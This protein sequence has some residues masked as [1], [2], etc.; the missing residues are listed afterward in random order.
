MPPEKSPNCS[1]TPWRIGS[2]ASKRCAFLTTWMPTHSAAQWSI[3]AKI[4][5]CPSRSV[6][7][8]VAS[9]P[10]IWFGRS[11]TNG[12]V[13][14]IGRPVGLTLG[15]QQLLLAHH[16]QDTLFPHTHAAVSQSRPDLAIS[17]A[18]ED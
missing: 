3:A 18:N 1:R 7:V 14:R 13:V 8:E 6:M 15:R 2:R 12:S 4:V 11:V 17:F 10:Q 9:V 5:T 16:P